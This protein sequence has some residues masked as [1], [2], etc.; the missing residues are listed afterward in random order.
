[1][2]LVLTEVEMRYVES[3]WEKS[4]RK[5]KW[6]RLREEGEWWREVEKRRGSEEK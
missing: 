3:A 5:S 2:A 6:V 4:R 1:M